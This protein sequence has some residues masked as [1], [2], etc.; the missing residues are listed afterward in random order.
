MRTS[1]LQPPGQEKPMDQVRVGIIGSAFSSNI[2]AEAFEEVPEAVIVAGCSP[3]RAH[4]AEFAQK[5]KV[6]VAVTDYRQVLDLKD[7]DVGVVGIPKDLRPRVAGA[8]AKT[9]VPGIAR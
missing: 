9:G 2:H 1:P 3:N 7:I 6:P 4:V 5:W 8:A